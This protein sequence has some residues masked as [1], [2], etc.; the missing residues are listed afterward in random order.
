MASDPPTGGGNPGDVEIPNPEAGFMFRAEMFVMNVLLGYA[1]VIIGLLV[2]ILVVALVIG[3]YQSWYRQNQRKTSSEIANVER[4]LRKDLLL[5]L[6]DRTREIVEQYTTGAIDMLQAM[7]I[8]MTDDNV[9]STIEAADKLVALGVEARG[10]ARTEAYL[11]AAE[12]YRRVEKVEPERQA[13]ESCLESA[14]GVLAYTCTANLVALDVDE[15]KV[16][17][18]VSRLQAAMETLPPFSA[19]RAALS[20][21]EIYEHEGRTA[22][23]KAVYDTYESRW[24]EAA[25][26]A[27]VQARRARLDG[28]G[29]G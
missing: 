28:G 1:K 21:A 23:A 3:Q 20:L 11:R 15:D 25:D 24:P 22:D 26:L 14:E 9:A 16:E 7:P 18:A 27:D 4:E 19:Q 10:T 12:L 17:S 13:L 6:D 29:E 5:D 8:E 2:L